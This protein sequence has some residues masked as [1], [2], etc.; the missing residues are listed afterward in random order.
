[1][2]LDTGKARSAVSEDARERLAAAGLLTD[3]SARF[4][5]SPVYHLARLSINNRAVPDLDVLVSPRASRLPIDGLLGL[6]FLSHFRHV[7]FDVDA[8]RFS[9]TRR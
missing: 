3:A 5:G 2:V 1:M 7:H 4:L 6:D 9:L 8:M